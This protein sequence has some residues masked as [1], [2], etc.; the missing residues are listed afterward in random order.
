[1]VRTKIIRVHPIFYEALE[2]MREDFEKLEHTTLRYPE[3][4]RRLGLRIKNR[5]NEFAR[6]KK[7]IK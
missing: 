5:R 1:M 4:T 6:K 2:Q 3:L 7:W